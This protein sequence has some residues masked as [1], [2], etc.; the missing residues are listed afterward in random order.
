MSQPTTDWEGEAVQIY[1]EYVILN[2]KENRW[3]H[4]EEGRLIQNGSDVGFCSNHKASCLSRCLYSRTFGIMG[5]SGLLSI[6]KLSSLGIPEHREQHPH[7]SSVTAGIELSGYQRSFVLTLGTQTLQRASSRPLL[8]VRN[9]VSLDTVDFVIRSYF[10][11]DQGLV[12]VSTNIR[13]VS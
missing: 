5:G 10:V 6:G 1:Q 13:W 9:A 4:V 12:P 11:P 7:R 2:A 3:I 8:S